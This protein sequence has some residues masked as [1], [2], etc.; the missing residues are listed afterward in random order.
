MLTFSSS[1]SSLKKKVA[2]FACSDACE[3][4]SAPPL[5]FFCNAD[6][7]GVALNFLMSF[8]KAL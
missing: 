6:S 3:S 2:L 4:C 5:P 8:F 1:L 7:T